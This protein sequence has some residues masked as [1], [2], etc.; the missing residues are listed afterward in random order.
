M[1]GLITIFCLLVYFGLTYLIGRLISKL[2]FKN[3]VDTEYC[4]WLG[5][6]FSVVLVFIYVTSLGVYKLIEHY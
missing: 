1:A 6:V 3:V 4:F 5:I 2:L